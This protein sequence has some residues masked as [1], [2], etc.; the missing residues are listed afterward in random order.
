M[1]KILNLLRDNLILVYDGVRFVILV[2]AMAFASPGSVVRI[3]IE[4]YFI[5]FL[6]DTARHNRKRLAKIFLRIIEGNDSG[7]KETK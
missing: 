5:F 2:V 7:E 4:L 3:S 1:K 6:W